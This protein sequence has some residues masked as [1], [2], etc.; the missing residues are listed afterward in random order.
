MRY[1]NDHLNN[2]NHLNPANRVQMQH[3]GVSYHSIMPSYNTPLMLSLQGWWKIFISLGSCHLIMHYVCIS[4]EA[5]NIAYYWVMVFGTILPWNLTYYVIYEVSSSKTVH[6]DEWSIPKAVVVRDIYGDWS[7]H[8]AIKFVMMMCQV[9]PI[10]V[11]T[12]D[13]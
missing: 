4:L 5:V 12:M 13:T 1:Y 10:A 3:N 8:L 7:R 9:Y 11:E 2:N 6:V